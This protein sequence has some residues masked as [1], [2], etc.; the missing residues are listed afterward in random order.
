MD[1]DDS[2]VGDAVVQMIAQQIIAGL[3]EE[4]QAAILRKGIQSAL[5]DYSFRS[6]VEKAVASK[7]Q[8][9]VG[10]LLS[11]GSAHLAVLRLRTAQGVDSLLDQLPAAVASTLRDSIFGNPK[12]SYGQ[13]R[14]HKYLKIPTE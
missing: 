9:I 1:I 3:N 6:A 12:E 7:A 10:E 4:A 8:E 5:K 14:I 2:K 11:E 13:S